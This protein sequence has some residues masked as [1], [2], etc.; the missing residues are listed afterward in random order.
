MCSLG[1]TLKGIILNLGGACVGITVNLG[2]A[3]VRVVKFGDAF[4][5]EIVLSWEIRAYQ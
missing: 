2:D 5:A 1:G 3:G 4:I